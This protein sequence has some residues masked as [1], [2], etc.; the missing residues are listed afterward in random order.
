MHRSRT[1][2]TSY[3]VNEVEH[4]WAP[5]L[6]VRVCDRLDDL[7]RRVCESMPNL[8]SDVS[9]LSSA[10]MRI[11]G[12]WSSTWIE[13][14]EGSYIWQ[15]TPGVEYGGAQDVRCRGRG[16]LVNVRVRTLLR[17][18]DVGRAAPSAVVDSR[19]AT[20][21]VEDVSPLKH[22]VPVTVAQRSE[23]VHAQVYTNTGRSSCLQLT[24]RIGR[25][26]NLGG[27]QLLCC[28]S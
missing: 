14:G 9:K 22:V 5:D 24:V 28:R 2:Y 6:A 1:S 26:A 18:L 4:K 23:S 12:P 15:G 8:V 11:L 7:G 3:S 13:C 27:S 21:A 10:K 20:G 17:A 25:E 19:D 16:S